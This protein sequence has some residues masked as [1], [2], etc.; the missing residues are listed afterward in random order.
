M[1][2]TFFGTERLKR[3]GIKKQKKRAKNHR[4]ICVI[5][6]AKFSN[7]H[8]FFIG[9]VYNRERYFGKNPLIEYN[10]TSTNEAFFF[11]ERWKWGKSGVGREREE[12]KDFF[13]FEGYV[14]PNDPNSEHDGVPN[15]TYALT[16][17]HHWR[18]SICVCVHIPL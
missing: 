8:I 9:L 10:K 2:F 5:L 18:L 16:G 15:F 6:M 3:L 7:D 11:L 1:I 13:G 14:L 12:L 17:E 4:V